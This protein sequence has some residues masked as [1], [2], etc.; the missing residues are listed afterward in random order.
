MGFEFYGTYQKKPYFR[1]VSLIY[2]PSSRSTWIRMIFF[3]G[4]TAVYIAMII[5][6]L[7]TATAPKISI[8]VGHLITFTVV[9]SFTFRPYIT[10][11]TRARKDWS[12]PITHLPIQG[13][14]SEQG[15]IFNPG[16]NQRMMDWGNFIKLEKSEGYAAMVAEDDTMV[17][18]QRSFFQTDD[19]WKTL[20]QWLERYIIRVH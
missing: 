13:K 15:V 9:G 2:K 4:F 5:S 3:V 20:D 16:A 19:E 12:D 6:S 10:A 14:V 17:L 1:A 7:K 18:L 11:Y 8:L